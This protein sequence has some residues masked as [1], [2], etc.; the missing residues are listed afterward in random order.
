[1]FFPAQKRIKIFFLVLPPKCK[2]QVSQPCNFA[3]ETKGNV[4][5]LN[6]KLNQDVMLN[7]VTWS[8]YIIGV[9][10]L[11]FVFYLFVILKFYRKELKDFLSGKL[12]RPAEPGNEE[13]SVEAFEDDGSFEVLE[14]VVNELRQD[15]LEKAGTT[16][17]REVL[18]SQMKTRLMRYDGMY[19]PAYRV[20]VNDY[21][22]QHAEEICGVV[23]S[24]E[25]LEAE[26]G[27]LPR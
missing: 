13:Q 12:K 21:I 4:F 17:D 24:E 23:F 20:A 14:Q 19:R 3:L 25:E 7:D 22:M 9:L 2:K 27:I 1:V 5:L 16:A 11:L 6:K 10:V 18:L 15:I 26:W 8:E